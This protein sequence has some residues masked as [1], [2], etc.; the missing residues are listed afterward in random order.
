MMTYTLKLIGSSQSRLHSIGV[1]I[2][3]FIVAGMLCIRTT[4][5]DLNSC[6]KTYKYFMKILLRIG[7]HK[8]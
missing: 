3:S 8:L 7:T 4:H 2:N 1:D 6:N 5:K